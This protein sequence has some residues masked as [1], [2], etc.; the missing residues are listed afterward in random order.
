MAAM[1]FIWKPMIMLVPP[2]I[3]DMGRAIRW[4]LIMAPPIAMAKTRPDVKKR[5]KDDD[6]N[7]RSAL[8]VPLTILS[9]SS[10]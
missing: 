5:V 3:S 6:D 9:Y 8:S 2:T 10:M 1:V 4:K 7:I